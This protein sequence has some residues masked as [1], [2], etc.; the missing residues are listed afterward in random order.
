MPQA[1]ATVAP[2]L[3]PPHVLVKSYGLRVVPNTS[4]KVCEPAPNSG[5]FVLPMTIAPASLYRW[6]VNESSV[7]T[8]SL[9]IRDP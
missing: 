9:N 2:P 1:N 6:T 4:L 3:L 8:K 5:V 7:G